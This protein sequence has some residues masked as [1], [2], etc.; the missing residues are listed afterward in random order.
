MHHVCLTKINNTIDDAR[1]VASTRPYYFLSF[2]RR[3][4]RIPPEL[5]FISTLSAF[6]NLTKR[7]MERFEIVRDLAFGVTS[8]KNQQRLVWFDRNES[9]Q[10]YSYPLHDRTGS[11]VHSGIKGFLTQFRMLFIYVICPLRTTVTWIL[12]VLI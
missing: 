8:K 10:P 3:F 2:P 11:W 6:H 9:T 1:Q 4:N 7:R 5:L 12:A